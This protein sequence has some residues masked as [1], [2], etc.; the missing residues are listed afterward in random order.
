MAAHTEDKRTARAM[1][2]AACDLLAE[3]R[4]PKVIVLARQRLRRQLRDVR[5]I[6]DAALAS[7]TKVFDATAYARVQKVHKLAWPPATPLVETA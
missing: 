3:G 1:A 4:D 6:D 2:K 5:M 7:I